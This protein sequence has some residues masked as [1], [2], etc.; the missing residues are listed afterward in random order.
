MFYIALTL[1]LA[2]IAFF[3]F[4]KNKK[5]IV[6]STTTTTTTMPPAVANPT[7]NAGY[8][9]LEGIEKYTINDIKKLQEIAL[10]SETE[11]QGRDATDPLFGTGRCS[12]A[13]ASLC[14]ATI[15]QIGFILRTDI[16][17]VN[18]NKLI[19]KGNSSNA[20]SFFSFFHTQGLQQVQNAQIE[21]I[22]YLF[23]NKITHN[24]FP[25][26]NLGIA[27]NSTNPTTS[28]VISINGDY[29][30]NINFLAEYIINAIPLLKIILS[31]PSNS[32]LILTV[33][34]N[35]QLIDSA[36]LTDLKAKF[37]RDVH[38]QRYFSQWLPHITF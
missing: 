38:L 21:A 7:G 33:D 24:L 32:A 12:S 18:V 14:F 22:Y 37:H 20:E 23:R 9:F 36:E 15:E 27:Q 30:I 25:K 19:K 8:I 3:I 11:D 5:K 2:A 34:H 35:I 26:H 10:R 6:S 13:L 31:N 4:I 1:L 16:T 17:S 29:S 28:L